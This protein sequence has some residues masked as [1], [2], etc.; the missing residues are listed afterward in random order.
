MTGGGTL[1]IYDI[2]QYLYEFRACGMFPLHIQNGFVADFVVTTD[3]IIYLV[4]CSFVKQI[5]LYVS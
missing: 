5:L 3:Y 4:T 2:F 1:I